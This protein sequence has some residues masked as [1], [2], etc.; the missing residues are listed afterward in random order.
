M[1]ETCLTY[2]TGLSIVH[3]ALDKSLS[4]FSESD[5][6]PKLSEFTVQMEKFE[7]DTQIIM[8]VIKA[9]LE[10]A[11]DIFC[12]SGSLS[13]LKTYR[14]I[15]DSWPSDPK[16]PLDPEAAQRTVNYLKQVAEHLTNYKPEDKGPSVAA[17]NLLPLLSAAKI[18]I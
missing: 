9:S 2:L 12:D 10:M 11:H 5:L 14:S 3:A 17:I 15:L 13:K 6:R 7:K 18:H 8:P 4:S 16:Q 1:N